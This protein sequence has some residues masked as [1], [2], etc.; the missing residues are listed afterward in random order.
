MKYFLYAR[1]SSESEDRQMAS[2]EDQITEMKRLADELNIEIYDVITESKSA[3]HPGRPEFNNMMLRI[4]R[5]EASGVLVWKLN[6]LARN[7]IDGGKVTWL[8]QQSVIKHIQTYGRDYKPTDNVMMMQVEFGMAI[9]FSNDLG[10]DVRR[11]LRQKADKGWSPFAKLPI[12]YIHAKDKSSGIEIIPHP[13]Y[14]EIVQSIWRQLLTGNFSILEIK[15]QGDMLGLCLPNG[16]PFSK[17]AYYRLFSN[18]F[19]CGFFYWKNEKG[20]SVKRVGKHIPMVSPIDFQR[21]Q[22]WLKKGKA[23]N[24]FYQFP[25]RG[26]IR[27]G[28][29]LGHVTAGH[30]HR[31]ICTNCRLKFS[32]KSMT[33]CTRCSTPFSK[34]KSPSIVDKVYYHCTKNKG[35]CSQRSITKDEIEKQIIEKLQSISIEQDFH[36]WAIPALKELIK[37]MDGEKVKKFASLKKRETELKTRLSGL[38]KMRADGE[39]DSIEYES[40]RKDAQKELANIQNTI[41]V[42]K[43]QE[44]YLETEITE[45]FDFCLN[46]L[47]RFEIGDDYERNLIIAKLALNPSLKDKTLYF[48]TDNVYKAVKECS[49]KYQAEKH[50]FKPKKSLIQYGVKSHFYPVSYV[51]GGY[52]ES[53]PNRRFHKPQC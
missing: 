19:Y 43:N 8:L 41:E 36:D 1:K 20:E 29:C 25:Y 12:G 47:K 45:A 30:L 26:L 52:R 5:G 13:H 35:I 23:R 50:S 4:E 48:I 49:L 53:N 17:N 34:M 44:G 28:E 2:I 14:F 40:Q 10:T 32:I 7:P 11:G 3:M 46:A 9:Q 21:A 51:M 6:R 31:A 27:C 18:I 38:I 33:E 37:G 24:R 39:I 15:R 42:T 22:N 16:K